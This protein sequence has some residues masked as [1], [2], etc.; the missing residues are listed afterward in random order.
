MSAFTRLYY[1]NRVPGGFGSDGLY[2]HPFEDA[3]HD[4][5]VTIVPAGP[6]EQ[7]PSLWDGTRGGRELLLPRTELRH[8]ARNPT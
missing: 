4:P 2:D 7:A 6:D 5:P 8:G 1:S 3:F